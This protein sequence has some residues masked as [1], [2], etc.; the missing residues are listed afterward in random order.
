MAKLT[1]FAYAQGSNHSDVAA[2][3]EERLDALVASRSWVT[4]DIWVVN[5]RV[6]GDVPEWDLGLNLAVAPPRTRPAE[7]LD[8]VVAIAK[9]LGELHRDTG[10][11]FVIGMHDDKTDT[12]R[13]LYVIDSAAP[14]PEKL[15]AALA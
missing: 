5:Q 14:D 6:P 12:T 11:K 8:D 9:V 10:T 1:L 3:V 2:K 7:W 15:K 4:K 13:D